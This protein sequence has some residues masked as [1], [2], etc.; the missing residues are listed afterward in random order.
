VWRR[1]GGRCRVPGCRSA[2][3]IEVHHI[4]HRADGGT[5]EPA[6][7]VLLCS[8]CHQ[9]HHAGVLA[10]SGTAEHLE[11]RRPTLDSPST[12]GVEASCVLDRGV[13]GRA[14]AGA[15]RVAEAAL[16][17]SQARFAEGY[18]H[19]GA[20]QIA[21]DARSE[22]MVRSAV[23][24]SGTH[25]GATDAHRDVRWEPEARGGEAVPSRLE[26]TVLRTQAKQALV[27]LGWKPAI[28]V[29]AVADASAVL[30]AQATLEQLIFEALRRCPRPTSQVPDA[31]SRCGVR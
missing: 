13:E 1:D 26:T 10:I 9:A 27:G 8:S 29:P 31:S 12:S 30:G 25:V 28:A 6:G 20:P 3:G 14:H 21:E 16:R 19:A 18:A 4:V 5:H 11:V 7:L 15:P 2:R 22:P 23:A 24:N 17:D